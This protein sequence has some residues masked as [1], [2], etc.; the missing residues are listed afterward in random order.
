MYWKERRVRELTISYNNVFA[1]RTYIFEL[2][3]YTYYFSLD[4]TLLS[5]QLTLHIFMYFVHIKIQ[6]FTPPSG[7]QTSMVN[8]KVSYFSVYWQ[9][10]SAKHQ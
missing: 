5:F 2:P 7:T 6:G 3:V 4:P 10:C 1:K 9:R 8:G